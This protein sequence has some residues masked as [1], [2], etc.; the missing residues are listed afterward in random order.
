MPWR[1]VLD[2]IGV[3]VGKTDDLVGVVDVV[4][5]RV[6]RER[7]GGM[8]LP[9]DRPPDGRPWL[10]YWRVRT[11]YALLRAQHTGRARPGRSRRSR[12]DRT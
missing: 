8:H 11:Q 10:S 6:T 1:R 2:A 12:R 5:I 7:V 4:A 3:R 9:G